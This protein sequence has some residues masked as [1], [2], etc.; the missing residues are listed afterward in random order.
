MRERFL[1]VD[2]G[3]RDNTWLAAIEW[4]GHQLSIPEAPK[5]QK[6]AE[7]VESATIDGTVAIAIDAQLSLSIAESD[8]D[9]GPGFRSSDRKLR[10]RLTNARRNW[11]ASFNSLMAI[12][13]RGRLLADALKGASLGVVETHPRVCL[14]FALGEDMQSSIDHYKGS[15]KNKPSPEAKARHAKRLLLAWS[16]KFGIAKMDV[17]GKISDGALDA[18]V[19]ATVAYLW[20]HARQRLCLLDDPQPRDLGTE[21]FFVVRLAP[22]A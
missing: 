1:G 12:P 9:D 18:I 5:R 10:E 15:G 21:Q 8:S 2:I 3:G 7:I 4:D 16:K 13:I 11:V 17:D 19:C 22:E 14:H 6:L 20:C